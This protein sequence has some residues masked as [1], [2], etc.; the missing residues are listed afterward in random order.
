[1]QNE[2][3]QLFLC[4]ILFFLTAKANMQNKLNNIIKQVFLRVKRA[5]EKLTNHLGSSWRHEC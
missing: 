2:L 5:I 3:N 1:M 4:W